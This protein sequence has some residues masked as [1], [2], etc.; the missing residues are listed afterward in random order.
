MD[1]GTTGVFSFKTVQIVHCVHPVHLVRLVHL[2]PKMT[3]TALI[4]CAA[5]AFLGTG[6]TYGPPTQAHPMRF[7]TVLCDS[8][9]K[10]A[11]AVVALAERAVLDPA[12]A[13]GLPPPELPILVR[14]FPSRRSMQ[15]HLAE[16]ASRNQK[17][18]AVLFKRQ[19]GFEAVLYLT[20]QPRSS[21]ALL[22]HELAHYVLAAHFGQ[23]PPWADEGLALYFETGP[24]FGEVQSTMP[25]LLAIAL[26]Q[27]EGALDKLVSEPTSRNL[28]PLEY[29]KSWSLIHYLAHRSDVG[30]EGVAEYLRLARPGTQATQAFK[31]AFGQSPS[32]MEPAWRGHLAQMVKQAGVRP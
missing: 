32:E 9:A 29:A 12:E 7:G 30:L 5:L 10:E 19:D 27:E 25:E 16:R 18:R 21:M 17:A 11:R 14:V 24:P 3:K 1:V 31:G 22:R 15:I 26:R 4:L 8:D 6:C 23:V 28:G 2:A 13:L 20:G